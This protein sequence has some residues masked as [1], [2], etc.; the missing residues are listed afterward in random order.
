MRIRLW[1]CQLV[2]CL[3][4]LISAG[5]RFSPPPWAQPQPAHFS[6]L[7]PLPS[8]GVSPGVDFDD[9]RVADALTLTANEGHPD[10][11]IYLSY[12]HTMLVLPVDAVTLG[13]GSLVVRDLDSDGDEDLV[14]QGAPLLAPAE[15]I[16][17]L[18]DGTGQFTRVLP[19]GVLPSQPLPGLSLSTE[20]H[21]SLHPP[22]VFSLQ[23]ISPPLDV[24]TSTRAEVSI[25]RARRDFSAFRP[26]LSLFPWL[27]SGRAPPFQ[28]V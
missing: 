15:V 27:P 13:T 16:V 1:Q 20:L 24:L 18:N 2:V 12:T 22:H 14:W 10:I 17:W 23:R 4:L 8:A 3:L 19:P 28:C 25:G 7:A 26:S 11:E 5:A 21:P 9:D 6:P